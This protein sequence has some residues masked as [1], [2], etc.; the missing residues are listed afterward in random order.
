MTDTGSV[1][2][3]SVVIPTRNRAGLVC[4]AVESVFR[5]T[6]RDF[7]LI[8]IDDASTDETRPALSEFGDR[9][10][11]IYCSK[12]GASG[13][14][15]QGVKAARGSLIAF[16]D[17]DDI[18]MPDKLERQVSVLENA[19]PG[20]VLAHG[21]CRPVDKE[22]KPLPEI[23][24]EYRRRY[25]RA[26]QNKESYEF[27]LRRPFIFTSSVMIRRKVFFEIG[28]YDTNLLCREDL[29]FYLRLLLRRYRFVFVP[30]P[31]VALYRIHEQG[32]KRVAADLCY[33][34]IFKKHLVLCRQL[35][36]GGEMRAARGLV[37]RALAETYYRLECYAESR[38]S[39]LMALR[40]DFRTAGAVSFWRQWFGSWPR[41]FVK[42]F[43]LGSRR[44][45]SGEDPECGVRRPKVLYSML[46]GEL[47]GGNVVCLQMAEEAR[48]RGWDVV[49][50]VSR[51]GP[52][53]RS[54][55]SGKFRVHRINMRRPFCWTE[56]F[57][58]ARLIRRERVDFVHSHGTLS[59]SVVSCLAGLLAGVPVINHAHLEDYF[60]LSAL[61]LLQVAYLE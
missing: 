1:P 11:Y 4:Q 25:R 8:V 30:A 35:T 59:V 45:F 54:F 12:Q 2:K 21:F 29:D 7:E 14:R 27:Y 17:A 49:V 55:L 58:M 48:R 26:R 33:L 47:T 56:T 61:F 57:R 15:N 34:K 53:R 40:D 51:G 20:C 16:L 44:R 39:W 52:V 28:G 38:R 24:K 13:A 50:T 5:Q 60:H 22:L 46:D 36:D 18:W 42:V 41:W 10:R 31:P 32:R 19:G 3:V 6:Y 9:I 37:R 43:S 23:E